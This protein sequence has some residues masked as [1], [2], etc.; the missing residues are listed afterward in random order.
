MAKKA[1]GILEK[2]RLSHDRRRGAR[3]SSPKLLNELLGMP[4]SI[5]PLEWSWNSTDAP[6]DSFHIAD[7]LRAP[8][9]C[10]LANQSTSAQ[11]KHLNSSWIAIRERRRQAQAQSRAPQ[12]GLLKG[13]ERKNF[14]EE[15]LRAEIPQPPAPRLP[16][17]E[18]NRL[19]KSLASLRLPPASPRSTKRRKNSSPNRLPTLIFSPA[20]ASL[21]KPL[22]ARAI[23]RRAPRHTPTLEKL[24]DFV[25]GGGATT[26]APPNSLQSWNDFTA[27]QATT[28]AL[29]DSENLRR[30]FQ[31]AAGLSDAELAIAVPPTRA[32]SPAVCRTRSRRVGS[33]PE[34]AAEPA[35]APPCLLLSPLKPL[36]W[37]RQRPSR[38]NPPLSRLKFQ[39]VDLSDEWATLL[40]A[41]RPAEGAVEAPAPVSAK[42][43]AGAGRPTKPGHVEEFQIG[44]EP[45]ISENHAPPAA[46]SIPLEPEPAAEKASAK[47]APSKPK[48]VPPAKTP[49]KPAETSEPEFELEQEYELVL[50]AEPL[51]P[52]Y[53]QRPPEKPIAPP[54]TRCAKRG[55][56]ATHG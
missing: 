45:A 14:P 19:L 44:E 6:V 32:A 51:V 50:E 24:L 29:N 21:R 22:V 16:G 7:A 15:N 34:I 5:E 52:A 47:P 2:S 10:L 38:S 31:R 17:D 12:N 25:L 20:T 28:A 53:D 39:E 40:D 8:R 27:K 26:G 43:A 49:P 33:I 11:R 13:G 18:E 30:R 46:P 23:L 36:P 9:R 54:Q 1:M 48:Q 37:R 35:P 55:A 3:R 56:I 4:G 42:P 41:S